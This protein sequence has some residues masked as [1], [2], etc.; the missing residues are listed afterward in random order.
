MSRKKT[1]TKNISFDDE[2]KVY[3]VTFNYG[4]NQDGKKH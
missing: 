2:R 1:S 3:Y 4:K